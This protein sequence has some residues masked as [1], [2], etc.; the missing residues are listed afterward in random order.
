MLIPQMIDTLNRNHAASITHLEGL[1]RDTGIGSEGYMAIKLGRKL[2]GTELKPAYFKQA[3]QY[4]QS[5]EAQPADLF[6]EAS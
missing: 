2:V 1:A 3:V 6:A 5:A 4:L